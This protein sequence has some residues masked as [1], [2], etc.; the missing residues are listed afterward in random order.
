MA[1]TTLRQLEYLI[2]TAEAGSF[3]AAALRL[4][5]SQST[6]SMAIADLERSLGV[7]LFLRKPRGVVV[8]RGGE[9]VLSDARRLVAGLSDLQNSARQSQESLTGPLVV[10]CYSTLSPLLLPRIVADF[11]AEHPHV[12]LTFVEG[13]H[14]HLEDQLRSGVLDVALLY[15]Y[16]P[17]SRRQ[18]VAD[19]QLRQVFASAPYVV[20][21]PGHRLAREAR[22]P[23]R[24]LV[25]EP[26]ILF[27]LPPGDQYF[28][29]L[30]EKAG[31]TPQVRFQT[32]S[33]ELVRA[34][35]ARGL[36]YSILSQHTVTELSYEGLPFVTRPLAGRHRALPVTA[37]TLAGSVLTR[38]AEAFIRQCHD[39]WAD[40]AG[41]GTTTPGPATGEGDGA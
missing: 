39:S 9:Q 5:V 17:S 27:N 15:D 30:F 37:V 2:A 31:L 40:E 26:M 35:V 11:V 41:S 29:S 12:E 20:L 3:S 13:S 24:A 28:R 36:G 18:H 19:L 4:H 14:A 33:F 21:H 1:D 10:G 34:L 22:V 16:R 23:L 25:D 6:L 7:Q 32:S 38:R 8:T